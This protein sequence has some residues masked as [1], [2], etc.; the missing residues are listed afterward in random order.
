M[1]T[2]NSGL[3]VNQYPTANYQPM[4][5]AQDPQQGGD[6]SWYN[7]QD[8][9]GSFMSLVGGSVANSETL[10][11]FRPQ[12]EAAGWRL[13]NANASGITDSVY[14]PS[15]QLYD[16]GQAFSGGGG[17]WQWLH[18]PDWSVGGK[19]YGEGGEQAYQRDQFGKMGSGPSAGFAGGQF[20]YPGLGANGMTGLSYSNPSKDPR[21]Q[22]L[23]DILM[24][25]A[26]QSLA[27][28]ASDPIIAN[29]VNSYR[30]E[31]MRGA[32]NSIDQQAEAQGPYSNLTS[33]RRL[34]NE[35]A[36]QNTGSMQ[37]ALMGHEVNARRQEIQHALSMAGGLLDDDS[38]LALQ[39]ELGYLQN[40]QF[41]RQLG[42]QA[43]DR[44][45][46]WD[47]LRSGLL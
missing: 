45:S 29:Q 31:Q 28:N 11:N 47:A 6:N 36:A 12:L 39:R 1:A 25:R 17:S 2:S 18:E 9:Q 40:D 41:L 30:A 35:R 42:L 37:A 20:N 14:T 21:N 24:Q 34:A 46:Y 23:Y 3:R 43:E 38:R 13:G 26:G 5:K 15:G 44:A 4:A 16:V 33:E 8:D 7:P 10:N 32:R 22:Q 27:P 19:Y